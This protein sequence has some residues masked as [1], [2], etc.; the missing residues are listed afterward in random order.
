MFV[1][2]EPSSWVSTVLRCFVIAAL[3]L[4]APPLWAQTFS[5]LQNGSFEAGSGSS[6]TNWTFT[7]PG[8]ATIVVKSGTSNAQV[9]TGSKAVQ[10]VVSQSGPHLGSSHV[11]VTANARYRFTARVRTKAPTQT[12]P[13][14]NQQAELHVVEWTAGGVQVADNKLAVSSGLNTFAWDTLRG[15]L[16]PQPTTQS[17]EVRLVASLPAGGSATYFWDSVDMTAGDATAWEPWETTLT[18]NTDFSPTT[19]VNPFKDLVLTGTFYQASGSTCPAPP[20]ASSCS[21][22]GCFQGYGFWDGVPSA[23]KTFKLRTL[24]PAGNWCWA[25][26]CTGSTVCSSDA[27]LNTKP[28]SRSTS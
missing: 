16:L 1:D 28:P 8:S 14:L 6:I 25:T 11:T 2:R 12:N 22:P 15:Y 17:V 27:G 20:S 7:G 26:R 4:M 19:A 10:M 21:A 23:G 24:F 3:A 9:D 18:S 13:N 5:S